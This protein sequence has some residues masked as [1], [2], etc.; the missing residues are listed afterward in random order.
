MVTKCYTT[1]SSLAMQLLSG[2]PP[3]DLVAEIRQKKFRLLKRGISNDFC[4][5]YISPDNLSICPKMIPPWQ[6]MGVPWDL[7]DPQDNQLAYYTDGSRIDN[8]VGC[9]FL[10][11]ECDLEIASGVYRLGDGNSVFEAEMYAINRAAI[12]ARNRHIVGSHL[13]S[14]SMS[15]L[16]RLSNYNTDSEFVEETKKLLVETGMRLHWVKAHSNIQW[17]EEVDLL[18]KFATRMDEIDI[19]FPLGKTTIGTMC[20]LELTQRWQERWSG[21]GRSRFLYGLFPRVG[22]DFVSG[23]FYLNQVLTLHGNSDAYK[24]RF[25][26]ED[27]N[28]RFCHAAMGTYPH[29]LFECPRFRK[30]RERSLDFGPPLRRS[31]L[32]GRTL[33]IIK[34]ISCYVSTN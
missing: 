8:R 28:C 1:T 2:I 26:N 22:T 24:A 19:I 23:D 7:E 34:E 3:L 17:N 33:D 32:E 25:F 4:G 18:A 14:D 20:K 13:Y 6:K 9:A 27:E 29:Y 10:L 21:D 30:I 15:A 16:S 11:I 12:H 5:T 31:Q